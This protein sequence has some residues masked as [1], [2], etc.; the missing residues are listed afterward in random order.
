MSR[1]SVTDSVKNL[2]VKYKDFT[3][4]QAK[5]SPCSRH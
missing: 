2:Y 1:E 4:R 5:Q 3:D